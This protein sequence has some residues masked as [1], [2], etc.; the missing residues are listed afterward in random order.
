MLGNVKLRNKIYHPMKYS[1]P[2]TNY[3]NWNC[4][5]IECVKTVHKTSLSNNQKHI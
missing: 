3:L 5:L 2:S 1:F 4:N